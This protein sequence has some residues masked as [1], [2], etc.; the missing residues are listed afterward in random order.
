MIGNLCIA[1]QRV[2]NGIACERTAPK[3]KQVVY[4]KEKNCALLFSTHL[5]EL[6]VWFSTNNEESLVVGRMAGANAALRR[7]GWTPQPATKRRPHLHAVLVVGIL[8]TILEVN[9]TMFSNDWDVRK[10]VSH[11]TITKLFF[12]YKKAH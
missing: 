10:S 6:P 2:H 1:Q 5:V 8:S 9:R 11:S 12:I 3:T 7:G 4:W